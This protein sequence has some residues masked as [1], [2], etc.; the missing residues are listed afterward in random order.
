MG[1]DILYKALEMSGV[2][3]K[4]MAMRGG[5]DGSYLYVCGLLTPNYFT[6]AHNFHSNCE[7]LPMNSWDKSLEVTLSLIRIAA[8]SRKA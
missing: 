4:T 5:T 1:I 7:F 2:E 6:G 8:E 3:A